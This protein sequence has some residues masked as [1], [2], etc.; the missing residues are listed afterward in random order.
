MSYKGGYVLLSP[1]VSKVT[2]EN[3]S[4]LEVCHKYRA[5]APALDITSSLWSMG[6]YLPSLFPDL[7]V[8]DT[9]LYSARGILALVTI[10][11]M[12]RRWRPRGPSWTYI[13]VFIKFCLRA[14]L[15]LIWIVKCM[16]VRCGALKYVY[17]SSPCVRS[18]KAC[19]VVIIGVDAVVYVVCKCRRRFNSSPI[20]VASP[21]VWQMELASLIF[22]KNA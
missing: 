14:R 20:H 21:K 6:P 17:G 12:P 7:Y 10:R 19:V 2:V 16:C 5:C 3:H 13:L 9:G 8:A 15:N 22:G 1:I 11:K 18:E 4:L